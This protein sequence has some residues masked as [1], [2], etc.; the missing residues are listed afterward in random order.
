MIAGVVN[1]KHFFGTKPFREEDDESIR[2]DALDLGDGLFLVYRADSDEI[3]SVAS[4]WD[5][6]CLGAEIMA[7]IEA[8]RTLDLG[9]KRISTDA[10]VSLLRAATL[11][12]KAKR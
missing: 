2:Y 10:L 8:L 9:G 3:I 5:Q 1:H 6:A 11:K 12:Q 4:T 7:D